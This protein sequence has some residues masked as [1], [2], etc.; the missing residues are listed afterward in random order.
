MNEQSAAP[1]MSAARN[2]ATRPF[3]QPGQVAALWAGFAL[4]LLGLASALYLSFQLGEIRVKGRHQADIQEASRNLLMALVDSEDGQRGFLLTGNEDYLEPYYVSR[5]TMQADYQTLKSLLAADSEH[6]ARLAALQPLL[7]YKIGELEQVID[8]KRQKRSNEALRIVGGETNRT[9]TVKLRAEILAING[10]A[11]ASIT[12]IRAQLDRATIAQQTII[13]GAIILGLGLVTIVARARTRLLRSL[14]NQNLMLE[15]RV[16]ERTVTLEER[17]KR[18]ETLIQDMSHRIGNSLSLVTSFLDLQARQSK[19]EEV[20]TALA[21]A[22]QRVFSIATAQRRMRLAM[23][24][25]TVEARHFFETLIDD[26]RHSLPDDR[27][28]IETELRNV[29]LKSQDASAFGVILNELLANAAKHAWNASER[30]SISVIFT[31]IDEENV[32]RISDDGRG[33]GRQDSA[34]GLGQVLVQSL[35]QSMKGTL[36]TAPVTNDPERPGLC[37]VVRA[38]V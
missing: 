23:D 10:D 12:A 34:G 28:T 33:G 24:S 25:D 27:I 3:N 29:A 21:A 11:G 38:P 2:A 6:A 1:K 35:V 5:V 7:E 36:E 30:G 26:F 16:R 8:L 14:A 18:V 4:F 32:L 9:S 22:R 15:E 13:M 20:K 19:S 31:Q 37:A 17:T